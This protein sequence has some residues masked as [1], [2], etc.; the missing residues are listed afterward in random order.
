ME[1]A[2]IYYL[3]EIGGKKNQEDF[4]W[5]PAGRATAEDRIFIVCDGVGGSDN[6][7]IASRFIAEFMS[8]KIKSYGESEISEELINELLNEARTK[9]T[10]YARSQG[11]N[12]E[13][14]TT[15]SLL[16]LYSESVF[17]A[18]CGDTRIYHLRDGEVLYKTQDHSLVNTL[19]KEGEITEEEARL[20]PQKNIILRAV[21]ADG[22]P[23]EAEAQWVKDIQDGDYFFMCTD[24]VLEN[25]AD[26]DIKFLVNQNDKGKIDLVKSFQQFCLDKTRDNYSM[27]L[28]KVRMPKRTKSIPFRQKYVLGFVS[29]IL[30]SCILIALYLTTKGKKTGNAIINKKDTIISGTIVAPEKDSAPY[31]E[32]EDNQENGDS[33]RHL[34]DRGNAKK[35]DSLSNP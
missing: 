25:I 10:V 33:V 30:L 23:I 26:E 24:G 5:P 18:W 19:V 21:K 15:F 14:A 1:L 28:L 29:L 12:D 4:I 9:L 34:R 17:I 27:Y 2:G 6:G 3:Y 32:V 22:S 13:M 7:E 11:L 16:V 35:S 20:H 31:I 8:V